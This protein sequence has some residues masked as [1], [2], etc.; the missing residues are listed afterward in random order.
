MALKQL[1]QS[2][3]RAQFL[4][5]GDFLYVEDA[6][7]MV[8]ITLDKG[9]FYEL[10]KGAQIK[11]PALNGAT[12]T[13]ENL[14]DAGQV[15]LMVG[16]GEY[17]PPQRDSIAVTSMPAMTIADGQA[18]EVSQMPAMHIA[19]GQRIGVS[20]LPKVQLASGQS[21]SVSSLP[22]VK[23]ATGQTVG[24]S[25]LPAVHIAAG[26]SVKA[27]L[28]ISG[29]LQPKAGPMPLTIAANTV[30]KKIHIKA[31]SANTAAITIAGVYELAAGETIELE[32][33]AEIALTGDA[34]NSAQVLEC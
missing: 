6:P 9:G 22:A 10:G 17:V 3:G 34:A 24:V 19:S 18:V 5:Q 1:M 8:R 21:V 32:T 4:A 25:T 7:S 33:T 28:Q 20:S 11:A 27:S 29:A 26:Q 14:G 30:R 16:F 2:R 12:I 15:T 13:V 31:S 23:M